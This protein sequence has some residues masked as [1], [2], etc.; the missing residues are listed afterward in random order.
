MQRQ[1]DSHSYER[2]ALSLDKAAMLE[3]GALDKLP[4]KILAAEV[5]TVLPAP[6]R[7]TQELE[8]TRRALEGRVRPQPS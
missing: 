3:R 8:R 5:R 6:D 4:N 7:L 2:T 1:I